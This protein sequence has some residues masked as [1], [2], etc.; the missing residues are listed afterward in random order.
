MIEDPKWYADFDI[1]DV[2]DKEMTTGEAHMREFVHAM[3]NGATQKAEMMEFVAG[4]FTEILNGVK[5]GEALKFGAGSGT[6]GP[7]YKVKQINKELR[8]A[9]A[10]EEYIV[11]GLSQNEAYEKAEQ[12]F[13]NKGTG[14]GHSI[15]TIKA[16]HTKLRAA[17]QLYVTKRLFMFDN[18]TFAG[19]SL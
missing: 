13:M 18:I 16:H 2:I 14:K 15:D 3:N 17:A 8:H 6:P 1:V 10:V 5:P 4:A 19:F 7:A 11:Q 12:F 9:I